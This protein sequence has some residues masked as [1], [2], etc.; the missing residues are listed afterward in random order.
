VADLPVSAVVSIYVTSVAETEGVSL[1]SSC[2][3]SEAWTS[4][5]ASSTAY[6]SASDLSPLSCANKKSKSLAVA[7]FI[8][9]STNFW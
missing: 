9:S 4:A 5:Y 8:A 3:K 6:S 1:D 2:A 7:I